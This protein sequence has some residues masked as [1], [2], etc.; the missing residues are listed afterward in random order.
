M[1][2]VDDLEQLP[3][4][5]SIDPHDFRV[6]RRYHKVPPDLE[7]DYTVFRVTLIGDRIQVETFNGRRISHPVTGPCFVTCDVEGT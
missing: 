5:N 6:G 7:H 4:Y 1:V 2:S 3:L